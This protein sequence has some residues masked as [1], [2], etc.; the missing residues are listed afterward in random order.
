MPRHG[1]PAHGA[2]IAATLGAFLAALHSAPAE[3]TAGLVE[4][5]D[6]PLALWLWEAA[7]SYDTV[8]DEVPAAHRPRVE[9]F[10]GTPPPL[11]GHVPV[12]SHNDLGIEHV[13]VDPAGWTVTGVID[14][15]DAAI[16]DPAYDF[17]LLYRDLG[18]EALDA[19]MR[20]YR[21]EAGDVAGLTE[22][23]AFYARCGALE[24]LAYGVESGFGEYSAKSVIAM[25]WL[26]PA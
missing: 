25:E 11:D 1:L 7:E 12:F 16:V 21:A 26:F 4:P 5:D 6:R 23:A 10:L 3:R 15:T 13:L 20:S 2:S 9:E 22:R 8:A 24:D 17:G 14:W 18:P 19:A